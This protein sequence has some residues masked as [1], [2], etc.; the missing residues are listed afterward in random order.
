MCKLIW[1]KTEKNKQIPWWCF[2][3]LEL[4]RCYTL[5]NAGRLLS[6]VGWNQWCNQQSINQFIPAQLVRPMY[7]WCYLNVQNRHMF[8]LDVLRVFYAKLS[9]C[10]FESWTLVPGTNLLTFC[11]LIFY[12]DI[13]LTNKWLLETVQVKLVIK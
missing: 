7:F 1:I 12:I 10:V 3:W 4:G 11:D 13:I 8:F 5:P 2:H 6:A 9:F